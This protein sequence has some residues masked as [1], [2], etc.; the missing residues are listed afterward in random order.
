MPLIN[1]Q[2]A[3][4]LILGLFLIS[5][6]FALDVP[7]LSGRVNDQADLLDEA[8]ED[9][10]TATLQQLDQAKGAQL[11][12][13]TIPSLQG[14]SLEDFSIRV[15]ETWQLGRKGVDDGVLLLVARDDRQIRIEVGYG[16]E[17]VLTDLDSR[18]IIDNLMVPAFRTGDF[19]A[20]IEAGVNAISGAIKG[21]ADAIPVDAATV[22]HIP[23]VAYVFIAIFYLFMTPFIKFAVGL[24]GPGGW[25]L[26]LF[27]APFF[28][29]FP[30]VLGETIA[31]VSVL[32]WLIIVPILRLIWPED[33]QVDNSTGGGGRSGGRGGGSYSSGGGFSGGGGSFGGGGASGGW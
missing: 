11:A 5:A 18:R 24:K 30:M 25:F 14:D 12:V 19:G 8:A 29:L 22:D 31:L 10:I 28:Y 9:R 4:I 3:L 23:G 20:G 32:A 1:V 33:W 13:L 6:A 7:Y 15:A 16:L 21:E 2:R 17:G 26:Y 27:L